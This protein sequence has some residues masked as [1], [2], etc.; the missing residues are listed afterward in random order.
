M[1]SDTASM[2]TVSRIT[3]GIKNQPTLD[4]WVAANNAVAPAGGCDVL[5]TTI[6][7]VVMAQARGPLSSGKAAA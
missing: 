6:R 5:V 7:A 1:S 2:S 3:T 4:A